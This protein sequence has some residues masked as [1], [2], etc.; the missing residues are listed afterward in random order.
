MINILL[1]PIKESVH[2]NH[3]INILFPLKRYSF[4]NES[5]LKS[6]PSSVISRFEEKKTTLKLTKGQ[7]LFHEGCIP[8]G[9]YII[10]KG[11]V[12]KYCTGINGKEHLFHLVKEDS[13]FGYHNLLSGEPYSHSAACLTDCEFHLIPK[14]TFISILNNN[15]DVLNQLLK[16][17]SYEFGVFSN[18]SKILAQHNVRERTALSLIKLEDFFD[19][20]GSIKISRKDHSNMVGTSIESLVR[21]LH[22]LKEEK[23]IEIKQSVI[24]IIDINKLIDITNFI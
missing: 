6:L 24:K 8:N 10:K 22:D 7:V 13:I 3:M 21:V 19:H 15:Q 23:V 14:I 2:F 12:K 20:K 4:I 1:L 5:F 17:I 18:N 9:I 11:K 16:I